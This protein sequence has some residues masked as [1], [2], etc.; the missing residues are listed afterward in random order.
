[1]TPNRTAFIFQ[2]PIDRS[3]FERALPHLHSSR[4]HLIAG[5]G[6]PASYLPDFA[7]LALPEPLPNQWWQIPSELTSPADAVCEFLFCGRLLR[8][9]G[10]GTFLEIASLL[11]SQHF[12]VFGGVDPSSGDSLLTAELTALQSQHDNVHFAGSQCDPLLHLQVPYPVLL[13]PS[14]YGEGLPRAVAEAL[15]LG[16]PVISSRAATC[17]IFDIST[18]YVAE[19]DAPGDYLHCFDQLLA[20]HATGRLVPRMQAGRALVQRSLS[21]A[22][23]VEETLAVYQLLENDRGNSYLLNKDDARLHSWLAQ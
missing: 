7:E 15:A 4:N 12:T 2:N 18:I 20:D 16:I 11:E 8:S 6:V 23:I 14:N 21:E 1:M 3:L 19:G 10:I 5:S 17:G 22:G 9:K 13:V